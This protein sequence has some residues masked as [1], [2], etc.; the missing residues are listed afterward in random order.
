MAKLPW[1][2]G[3]QSR[4]TP[5]T[6]HRRKSSWTRDGFKT[7]LFKLIR[8]LEK[9]GAVAKGLTF[10]GLRHAVATDLR[11][12]GFDTRTIAAMLDQKCESMAMHYSQRADL[13][14]KLKSAVERMENAEKTP[15]ESSRKSGKRV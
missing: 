1:S 6:E 4:R 13:Q 9:E 14:D 12:L 7:S 3:S 10:H 15:T 11:E 2:A 5:G 8:T